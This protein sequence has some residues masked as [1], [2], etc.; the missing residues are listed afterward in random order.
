MKRIL[1]I[2][3]FTAMTFICNAQ[4]TKTYQGVWAMTWWTFDFYPD[5]TYQRTSS[6]HYGKTT[7]TGNYTIKGDTIV[8]TS[9]FENTHGTVNEKYLMKNDSCITD[10]T[11][12]KDYC[13]VDP[14]Y[15]DR[16]KEKK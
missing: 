5:S 6:G 9:G 16:E 14:M 15:I 2:S 7:V 1:I 10:L 4:E 12:K 13:L 11:L 8:L 3:I